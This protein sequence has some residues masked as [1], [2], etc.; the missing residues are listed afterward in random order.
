MILVKF[1]KKFRF[2]LQF[3]KNFDFFPDFRKIGI[4]ANI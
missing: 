2:W 1:S 3:T 4:S